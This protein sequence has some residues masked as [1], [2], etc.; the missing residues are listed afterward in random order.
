MPRRG[1][2]GLTFQDASITVSW[3]EQLPRLSNEIERD[4]DGN[5][6]PKRVPS[7]KEI[8]K[9]LVGWCGLVGRIQLGS[10]SEPE[11]T[12]IQA[13]EWELVGGCISSYPGSDGGGNFGASAGSGVGFVAYVGT[14]HTINLWHELFK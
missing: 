11:R 7:G 14:S 10:A 8:L 4:E 12:C 1:L 9:H 2:R 3:G 6:L 5:V 13:C